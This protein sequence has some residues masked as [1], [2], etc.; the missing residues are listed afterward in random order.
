[1]SNVPAPPQASMNTPVSEYVKRSIAVPAADRVPWYKST[2]PTYIGIFLW[3]GFYL[4]LAGPTIGQAN[5]GACLWGLL[6]AG[7]LC[8]GLY[9][10]VPAMLGMQTGHPLYVVGSSAFG[11]K[12]GY[13][14]PGILMGLL[15]VGW[16]SVIAAI[17]ADFIMKG[18]G[19]TSRVLFSIIVVVWVYSLGWIA[20]KG[21]HHVGRAAK[22]LNWI[23]LIMMLIVFWANKDG[24]ASYR[25]AHDD[26]SAGFLN[27]ISI[28]IGF[29]ATAGAAGADFGMNNR[30]RKDIVAGGVCGIVLG[31]LLAG[32]LPI[33]SVAGYLGRHAGPPSYNYTA[34]ISSVGAL[35]PVMF[36]LFAAASLVPTCFSS[37][38]AANSFGTM[39][40]KIPRSASTTAAI[41]VSALLAI[42]GAANNLVGFFGIVGASFGPICG[43]MAAEYIVS[44][45]RW[46]GPRTGVNWAGYIAWAIGFLVGIPEH[47]YGLPA[48]WVKADNPAV[49][50]S[51]AAG[52]V[53]YFALAKLG[54]RSGV[55]QPDELLQPSRG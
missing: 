46:A 50:Y 21:I 49:L 55:V 43:A 8:F 40:P 20:I 17:A 41:T 26:P 23:P 44:G 35:A 33:L 12:G 22:F 2:F 45:R 30:N 37:F 19:L 28:V 3:V 38:I 14:I 36:F 16:V 34:A 29:F 4:E 42:T 32:G 31:V 52:F 51:F 13:L 25:V 47:I 53:V 6:A 48:E 27:A 11:M 7:L 15:Q 5:L 24:I 1:M 39:L 54:L 10:Y 18:L 9:Y